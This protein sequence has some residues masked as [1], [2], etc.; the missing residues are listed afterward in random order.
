MIAYAWKSPSRVQPLFLASL[1]LGAAISARAQTLTNGLV[2]HWPMEA[3]QGNKTPDLVSGYDMTMNNLT[4]NDLVAGIRGTC[5]SFVNAR[6]TLLSRVHTAGED[7]PINKHAAFTVSMWTKVNGT[8]QN[9]LRVFSE[10]NTGA[11]DPLFNLGTHNVDGTLDI[12]IRQSGWTTVNH[13]ITTQQPFDDQWHQIV[14]VQQ[15]DGSRTVFIDGVADD[16][17]IPAKP[18]GTFNVN[19]TSIGGILRASPG[20]WVTGLID[21]VALWKRALTPDEVNE[22]RTNGVPAVSIQP[23]PLEIK[24]FLADFPTVAQGDKA[25]LRWEASKD[26]SLSISPGVGD[27]SPQTQFGV[28]NI[29]A[30]VA[31][32]TT[33]TLTATRGAETLTAQTTVRTVP[34]VAA[35]WRLVENFDYLSPGRIAGSGAWVNPEGV[36]SVVDLGANKVLGYEAGNALAALPLNSLLVTEGKS[37]TLFFRV[38]VSTNDTASVLGI[39]F[40]LT[41]RPIRFNGDFNGNVGPYLRLERLFDGATT[42]LLAHN[43]VGSAYDLAADA[44]QPGNVYRVWIDAEN[45][46]FDVQGGVQNGGDIYSVHIQKEGDATRTTLFQNYVADRDAVN[47]D[48]FFG[49]PGTNLTHLFFS[50]I[51]AAQGTNNVRFDD[52]YLSANGF[53]ASTPVPASSFQQVTSIQ[54]GPFSFN[55]ATSSFNLGWSTTVG[56]TYNVLK[57][58]SLTDP[59]WTTLATGYP[60]GGATGTSTSFTDSNASQA[61]AYYLISQ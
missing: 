38:Y 47:I 61:A 41:E 19:D 53:N 48:P 49:A 51:G 20:S 33:F 44:V 35:N 21:E 10:G 60:V 4:T 55:P 36:F 58:N 6:Q 5:F 28:G 22:V 26:A 7:L 14:F 50:A 17:P 11:S 12:F 3:V 8:G 57:K 59:S 37:N 1:L 30:T 25:M 56:A 31:N 27:V 24:K 13:I 43:G 52:F 15:T 46:P 2:S 42:D 16:L 39:T 9:D 34:N 54:I 18:A 40:G 32:T 29:E 23:L 45:R